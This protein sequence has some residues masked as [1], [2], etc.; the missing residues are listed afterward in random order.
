MSFRRVLIACA[1]SCAVAPALAG[2]VLVS[3]AASLTNAFKDL[4]TQYE[5]AHPDTKILTTFGASDVVLRQITE[6]APADIFAS[7]DQKAMDKAAAAQA[8][9][10]A[11]RMNFVRNEV[12]LVV[13]ADNPRQIQSLQDLA[14]PDVQRIALGNPDSVP[15]G[16]YTRAALEKAGAWEVVKAHEILGQNVRQVLSYVER[17]E[18]DAG[19][20]FATDAAIMKDK[21]KVVQSV[22][23]P[24]PVVYP[25]ALVRRD[26]R[27]PEAADFLKY[28][29]SPAGQAVLAQ[30]G[31]AKP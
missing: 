22:A 10:P 26:G 13:P 7:A 20:V 29:V 14:K 9:D 6:G 24:E 16:R 2:E 8:I 21:V 5:A 30:Y 4:A 3:A 28:V 25:I 17:G 12:V 11:S 19:F 31:F 18:V 27:A 15:V 1:L 23:T